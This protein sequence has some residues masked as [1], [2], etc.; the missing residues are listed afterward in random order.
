V[1]S[2]PSAAQEPPAPPVA[3]PDVR[4]RRWRRVRYALYSLVLVALV[5]GLLE[6]ALGRMERAG[7]VETRRP[8]CRDFVLHVDEP[9]FEVAGDGTVS[10]TPYA[11]RF[12]VPS[13]FREDKGDAFRVYVLGSS[14]A[15]G[16]PYTAQHA[17]RIGEGG[18][19]S[20]LRA[21][22]SALLPDRPVE[23]LNLASACGQT[24][25]RVARVAEQAG[26]YPADVFLI[27]TGNNEGARPPSPLVESLRRSAGFRLLVSVLASDP[28]LDA[29]S[30]FTPQ[31]MTPD[32]TRASY[33]ENI[34]A[35]L[36]VAE[37]QGA[38][39]VLCTLPVNLRYV[40]PPEILAQ[41]TSPAPSRA[42]FA[43]G[44]ARF[45]AGAYAAARRAL[46]DC[47]H[48]F[49][50]TYVGLARE[51]EGDVAGA[52]ATLEE[53]VERYPSNRT[54]PSLNRIVREEAAAHPGV[55]LVDLE[56]RAQALSPNGLPGPDL[57]Y[58]YCHLNWRGYAEMSAEILQGLQRAGLVPAEGPGRTLPPREELR[59][60]F[61]L[62]ADPRTRL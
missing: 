25:H 21:D 53:G 9:L 50:L 43:E 55:V 11:R 41:T 52:K 54:R 17:S 38:R 58:D 4:A 2:V 14:F 22:L 19:A 8:G 59:A 36:A 1:L 42:C 45:E 15:M 57:F 48:P 29:R 3:A 62:P 27:A 10:T 47:G 56:A 16:S 33:R 32:E 23:V 61:G 35:I 40:P 7:L 12:M 26:A 5:L 37:S 51:A 49:A 31:E 60:R 18:I 46:E 44:R 30:Y 39:A 28:Q 6:L 34:R 24:S 20:W 13:R